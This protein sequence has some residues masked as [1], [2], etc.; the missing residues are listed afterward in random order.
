MPLPK[1]DDWITNP[2]EALQRLNT[3]IAR[4]ENETGVTVRNFQKIDAVTNDMFRDTTHLT[5]LVGRDAFTRFLA[6]E[7]GHLLRD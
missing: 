4:I 1:N 5:A 3:V 2:P 7:Y 6:E